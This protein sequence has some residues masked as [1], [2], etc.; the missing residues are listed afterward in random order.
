M[1]RVPA[2]AIRTFSRLSIVDDVMEAFLMAV[3]VRTR[4]EG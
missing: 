4:Q 1:V 2:P 3:G